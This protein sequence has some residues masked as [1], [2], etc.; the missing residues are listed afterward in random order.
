MITNAT[1]KPIW[2]PEDECDPTTH[3]T[4]LCHM[5]KVQ[6]FEMAKELGIENLKTTIRKPELIELIEGAQ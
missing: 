1:V 2:P 3:S 4:E 5:T 6:L